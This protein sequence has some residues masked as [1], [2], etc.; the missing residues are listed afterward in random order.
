[1]SRAA[2]GCLAAGLLVALA[3]APPVRAQSRLTGADLVGRVTD[4]S[5]AVL[6]GA[7]VTVTNRDTNLTRT[8]SSDPQGEFRVPALPPGTYKVAVA[9]QGF[10]NHSR[11]GV[12]LQ[13]GQTVDL[14]IALKIA[15]TQEE[16]T[17]VSEA[18]TIDVTDTSVSSVVGQQQIE[19][20]PINGRSFISFS[21]IT[22]GVTTD[23]TPQQGASLTSGLSFTGQRARS[24]NIMVDGLDNND[25][26]VG[27]V[28]A[29]FSQEAIREFQ[30]VTDSYTAEFGK[31]TGGVVNIV[32]K[33]GTNE[34]HGNAFFYFRDEALNAKDYFEKNDVF[35]NSID[36]DKAPFSANQYGATLGGPIRKD[37]TFFFLSFE[38]QD[39]GA[40]NFV[41]ISPATAGLL[42]QKGFPVETGAVPFDFKIWEL[43]GKI[44]HQWS[45]NSSLVFRASY[46]DTHNEN[47]EPFGGIVAKSRGAVQLRKDW[48]LSLSQSNVLSTRWVNEARVQV[49]RQDQKINSLD[50]RCD[51]ECDT[52]LEGGPT[53]EVTGVASVGRQRFTPQPRENTRLQ[54]MDTVSLFSGK[55]SAKAGIDF[56]WVDTPEGATSLPLHFGGR[57]IFAS[58]PAVPALGIP[59]PLSALQA[60][61]LDLPAAYVQ[62]YGNS[63]GGYGYKDLSIFLQ[64]EWRLSRKLTIKAGLRYQKQFWDELPF[65]VSDLRGARYTYSFPQDGDNFAPRVSFAFD[66]KGNGRTSIHAA[67]GI[68]FDNNI[69][70]LFGV[71]EG[72]NGA[73]DGVRTLVLRFPTSIAPYRTPARRIPEP[74]TPY[75]SLEIS[76]DPALN[77]PWAQQV[78]AGFDQAL[79]QDFA[80]AANFIWVRG[81]DQVGTIDYNPVVPA[82]GAGRRPN[83]VIGVPA[84]SAS[85]LQYTSFGETWYRGLTLSLSKRLSHNYQFLVSYTFSKA[86]DNS[87][88]FQ[89]AFIPQQNGLGRNPADRTGLPTGFDPGLEKG[90]A[91]HD[92]RHRFVLSGLYRLPADFQLSTIITAASG[93]PYTPLAGADLNGDGDGG[94]FPSDRARRDPA[95]QASSV[96]RNSETMDAQVIVDLRLSKRIK[97]GSRVAV[98]LIA[99]AFNLFDRANFSEINNIFGRGTFPGTPQ[100]DAQGRVTYGL[101]EQALPPRQIQLAAK[102]SF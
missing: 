61:A 11:D 52:E 58:L 56:N 51:G 65:D 8:A 62:G 67:Y 102:L 57:Y 68:Y 30:V 70:A 26:V 14:E 25:I 53:L 19:N 80:L 85:V 66:P 3:V 76:I 63:F 46:S 78:A 28:R 74:T 33:S 99:E 54:L 7:I 49:A 24:N 95:N 84:T 90:P 50:P 79:G 37:K 29:T 81:K 9:I 44:D 15:G 64:D 72:I 87:T 86:E 89:S 35:G 32:T 23:R 94:A 17:I 83:D 47:I 38:R 5:G 69:A 34:L 31:A 36:R 48:S 41:N 60:L 2:F 88:D 45:P 22:P 96:G 77:T 39:V 97:L 4:E 18:P 20:L 27:A 73:T 71:T 55:H 43:L 16:V 13:L 100:T 82:L 59:A 40:S 21:I 92:Q 93:R 98:D 91:T 42:T 6:P 1:M 10:A 75:P 101:Y 12:T